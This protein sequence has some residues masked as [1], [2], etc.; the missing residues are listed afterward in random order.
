MTPQRM[1]SIDNEPEHDNEKLSSIC[2]ACSV[3]AISQAPSTLL[4]QGLQLLVADDRSDYSVRRLR[5]RQRCHEL[6]QLEVQFR[7]VTFRGPVVIGETS[8]L[9]W[10]L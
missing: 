10:R 6:V 2:Y 9:R 5:R 7:N 1:S 4:P 8:L 3:R